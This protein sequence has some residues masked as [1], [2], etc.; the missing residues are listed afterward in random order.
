MR[1]CQSISSWQL[2]KEDNFVGGSASQ[3]IQIGI[4]SYGVGCG[5]GVA[6]VYTNVA[7]YLNSNLYDSFLMDLMDAVPNIGAS[8]AN[9]SG[10]VSTLPGNLATAG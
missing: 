2:F 7:A 9:T 3:D 5:T 8:S 4:V 1:P 6:G 10:M